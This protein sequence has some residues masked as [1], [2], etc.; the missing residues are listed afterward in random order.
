MIINT[1]LDV[2]HVMRMFWASPPRLSASWKRVY[3]GYFIRKCCKIYERQGND[4]KDICDLNPSRNFDCF[5]S[6]AKS[7]IKT[8]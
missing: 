8:R 5:K 4:R 1:S 2:M 7:E 6:V 3:L